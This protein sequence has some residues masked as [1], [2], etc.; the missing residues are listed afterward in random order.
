VNTPIAAI[1]TAFHVGSRLL[2]EPF[3]WP[4]IGEM[5]ALVEAAGFRVERQRRIFRLPGFL[6]PPVLTCAIRPVR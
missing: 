6:L 2:G 1:S 4:T 3:Y 5:R